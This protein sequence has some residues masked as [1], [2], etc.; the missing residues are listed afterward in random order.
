[1][2]WEPVRLVLTPSSIMA[3]PPRV[4]N[5]VY[6]L[7]EFWSAQWVFYNPTDYPT[8]S[9]YERLRADM[10]TFS[11]DAAN[12]TEAELGDSALYWAAQGEMQV[13]RSGDGQ[14]ILH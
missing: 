14:P 13:T 12:L 8:G 7:Y 10:A 2:K 4:E 11:S 1:M 9:G 3:Q 6:G 5:I